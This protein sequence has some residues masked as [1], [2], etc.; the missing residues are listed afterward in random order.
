VPTVWHSTRALRKP[1]CPCSRMVGCSRSPTFGAPFVA[2]EASAVSDT[3]AAYRGSGGLGHAWLE[4]GRRRH[5]M[6]TFHDTVACARWCLAQGISSS[7]RMA[8]EVH[9]AGG[10]IAGYIANNHP[11]LFAA[12]ILRVSLL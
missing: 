12:M 4:Q 1:T 6:N 3:G 8:L 7:P 5:K 2:H 10:L 11:D 9:S